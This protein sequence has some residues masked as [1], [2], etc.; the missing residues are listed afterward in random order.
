MW[1]QEV[2]DCW[3][4]DKIFYTSDTPPFKQALLG[5]DFEQIF[6]FLYRN[7]ADLDKTGKLCLFEF[8]IA[9]HLVKNCVKGIVYKLK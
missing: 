8:T 4:S 9:M 7:I 1:W 6:C 3:I 2:K 5:P